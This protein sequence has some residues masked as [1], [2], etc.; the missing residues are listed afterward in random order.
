M[1]LTLRQNGIDPTGRELRSVSLHQSKYLIMILKNLNLVA[2]FIHTTGFIFRS[3]LG[4]V[5][6][7]LIVRE[8][9]KPLE[10]M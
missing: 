3:E 5:R 9:A 4:R 7:A 2:E 1:F 6:N 10:L 8:V